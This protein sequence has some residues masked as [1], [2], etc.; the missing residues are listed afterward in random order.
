[1]WFLYVIECEDGSLYTGIAVDVHKRF[2]LHLRGKGARYTRAHRPKQLLGVQT[3][4]DRGSALSAE[5]AF[6]QLSAAEKKSQL[7]RW[8]HANLSAR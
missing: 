2:A 3:Y 5:Y 6:K 4:P 7:R 1:M 8:P